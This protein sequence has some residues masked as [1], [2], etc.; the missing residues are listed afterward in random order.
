[1]TAIKARLTVFK[2][3]TPL[4]Y[5][6]VFRDIKVKYRGSVLGLFWSLLQPLLNMIV[7][8][9]VFSTLFKG[10][11]IANYPVYYL[12][13]AL[14]FTLNQEATSEAMTSIVYSSALLRKIYVPKYIFP[15]S[16]VITAVAN[17]VFSMLAMFL[18]MIITGAPFHWTL[19]F[20]PLLLAYVGM[21]ATGLGLFLAALTVRFRDIRYFYTVVL[22][23]WIY[24]T[25]IFYPIEI[26][27]D[28]LIKLQVLNPMFHF[29]NYSRNIVLYGQ[30]PSLTL[31][32]FC[33]VGGIL[34]LALG[35]KVFQK[36]QDTFVYYI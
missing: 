32:L 26:L 36:L 9:V 22:T 6:L 18:I 13:G 28:F 24:L 12:S 8:T 30:V 4:L 15:L 27:P 33:L 2:K 21:F 10:H 11:G 14:I 5:E 20:L 25:P 23:A 29:V 16:K 7:M 3:Y 17:C 1:M 19:I 34:M 35:I 31:N